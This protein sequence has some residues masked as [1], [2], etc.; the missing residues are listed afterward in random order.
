[1]GINIGL[2]INTLIEIENSRYVDEDLAL[3][4]IEFDDRK[5]EIF[6]NEAEHYPKLLMNGLE[7]DMYRGYT[8]KDK[9]QVLYFD[10][11]SYPLQI[12]VDGQS[13][14][15]IKKI[16]SNQFDYIYIYQFDPNKEITG[17]RMNMEDYSFQS[18]L[19]NGKITLD[20]DELK[21]IV[22][23]WKIYESDENIVGYSNPNLLRIQVNS[24]TYNRQDSRFH[25]KYHIFE[26]LRHEKYLISYH[27]DD[28]SITYELSKEQLKDFENFII[29]GSNQ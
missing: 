19:G 13:I 21:E 2:K 1:M 11:S 16:E 15:P 26:Q 8:N 27:S 22:D 6:Y 28:S 5:F 24:E 12:F 23:S 18:N 3:E 17:K 9:T 4:T 10:I 29:E 25:G 14:E 7:T 20:L